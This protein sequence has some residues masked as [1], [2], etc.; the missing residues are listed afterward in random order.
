MKTNL[1]TWKERNVFEKSL[2]LIGV[3]ICLA[4]IILAISQMIGK[5]RNAMLI[6]EPLLGVLI[7]IQALLYRKYNKVVAVFSLCVSIFIFFISYLVI[8]L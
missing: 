7:L 8:F 5:F 4:I 6:Y 3:A 1:P 2:T